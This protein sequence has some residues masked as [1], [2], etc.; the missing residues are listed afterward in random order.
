M[1]GQDYWN[2][3]DILTF[4]ECVL[5]WLKQRMNKSCTRE[6]QGEKWLKQKLCSENISSFSLNFEGRGIIQ[7]SS[8]DHPEFQKVIRDHYDYL[9][10]SA[11]SDVPIAGNCSDDDNVP[12]QWD[13]YD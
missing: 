2:P 4:L 3:N 13:D 7:L 11:A 1:I 9:E 6:R 10:A 5:C 12:D 8:D